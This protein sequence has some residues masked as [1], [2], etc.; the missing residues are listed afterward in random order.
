MSKS[1]LCVAATL[2]AATPALAAQRIVASAQGANVTIDAPAT[3]SVGVNFATAEPITGVGLETLFTGVVVDN[4]D[5]LFPWPSDIVVDVTSPDGQMLTW[6]NIGGD[7][8]FVDFP[9]ADTTAGFTAANGTG[10]YTFEF[11]DG[12]NSPGVSEL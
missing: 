10:T 4:A 2:L 8:S 1:I 3:T 12:F 11:S 9:L 5:G 7:R 6:V